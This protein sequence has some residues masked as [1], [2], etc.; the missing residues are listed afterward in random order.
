[1]FVLD[2]SHSV[3]IDTHF[4]RMKEFQYSFV[5]RLTIGRN[6]SQVGTIVFNQSVTTLFNLNTYNDKQKLL[7]AIHNTNR[8]KYGGTNIERALCSLRSAFNEENGGR[9][10]NSGVFRIAIIITDGI[11]YSRD[12]PCEWNSISEAADDVK[13]YLSPILIYVIGIT[14]KANDT[15]LQL[16]ST[17]INNCYSYLHIMD[18]GPLLQ[19]EHF[20]QVCKKGIMNSV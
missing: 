5:E 18:N 19:E 9:Q 8:K 1:M 20:N 16:I 4:N 12:S 10:P 14:K 13:E 11:P 6:H 7:S 15:L 2:V 3:K 17:S